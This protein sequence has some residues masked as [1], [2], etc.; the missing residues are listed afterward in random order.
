MRWYLWAF[1]D[2]REQQLSAQRMAALVAAL[3]SRSATFSALCRLRD[4]A[5]WLLVILR[6]PSS[7]D[8][9][10]LSQP[11]LKLPG[12][13]SFVARIAVVSTVWAVGR[14]R[15]VPYGLAR[16]SSLQR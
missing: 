6:S 15:A 13:A 8:N 12:L 16:F 2:V 3:V 1:Q 4:A 5:Y 9:P 11:G 14:Q 7:E 10:T